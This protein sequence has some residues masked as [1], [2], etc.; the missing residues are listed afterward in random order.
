[1]IK[2]LIHLARTQQDEPH[3]EF[4]HVG[5][6]EPEG[7]VEG[8]RW[9]ISIICIKMNLH[10]N[11]KESPR[12]PDHFDRVEFTGLGH[13][14]YWGCPEKMDMSLNELATLQQ[15]FV[16]TEPRLLIDGKEFVP[17]P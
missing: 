7:E 5:P 2:P 16:D 3:I 12:V 9:W 10:H 17:Y 4:R 8:V 6:G 13:C 11:A 14:L 15:E 1:M